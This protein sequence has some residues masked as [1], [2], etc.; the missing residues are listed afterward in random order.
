M[1][2]ASIT[3]EQEAVDLLTD[4]VSTPSVSPEISGG[5]GESAVAAK[6][7]SFAEASGATVEYQEALPGRANVICTLLAGLTSPT[8]MLEAHMD[9]VALG[10]MVNGHAPWLDDRGHLHGRGACDTKG[11]LAA[12]L[13]TLRRVA[14]E[15]ER[16][17]SL[18]LAATVDE[19]AGSS[20]ADKLAASCV[21][22]DGAIVGEPTSLEIVRVHRGGRFW[23]ITT[24]GKSA[25]SSRPD[26]GINAIYHMSDVIQVLR[27]EFTR[28]LADRH[29]PLVGSSTFS[30]GR[31][32][33]GT[34]FNVVPGECELVFDR[35]FLP[36]ERLEDVDAELDEVLS[37]ARQRFPGLQV[38]AESE[39]VAG[40]LDTPARE[41]IVQALSAACTAVIGRAKIAGAPYGSDAASLSAA[42][43][44]SVLCGP[45]DI[46]VAHSEDEWVPV[47]EVMAASD[48]YLETWRAFASAQAAVRES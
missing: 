47:S 1:S 48:I 34:S 14:R 26:L 6:V 4:L 15:D 39:V 10:S 11:S 13:L 2:D 23:R 40:S 44:P 29:H 22:A 30:A 16:K 12:M 27:T 45:G 17:C 20:G 35:R 28:R 42:G 18:M 36:D 7:A 25:H 9:T 21:G 24:T 31:I 43:I 8:L 46:A 5:T 38:R 32:R 33:A 41:P 19:E 37:I 3:Q